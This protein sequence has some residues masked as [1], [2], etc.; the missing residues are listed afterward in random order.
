MGDLS[1]AAVLPAGRSWHAEYLP[2]ILLIVLVA[3]L[4]LSDHQSLKS[5]TFMKKSRQL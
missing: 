1:H 3:V 5:F 4:V 2:A